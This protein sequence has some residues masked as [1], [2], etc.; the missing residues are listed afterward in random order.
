MSV[1]VAFMTLGCPKN[2][3]DTDAMRA[4]VLSSA[5]EL[6]EDIDDADVVVLNTCSFI[7]EATEESITVALQLAEEWLPHREGRRLL[8]AG[9]MPSRY[10]DDLASALV[11]VDSFIPVAEED[12][13]LARIEALTGIGSKPLV[14]G[15]RVLR[16]VSGPSA[17]VKISDGCDRTCA[18]CAIPSIRGPYRSRTEEAVLDEIE[19]LA[20]GGVRE[21]VLIGQ[22]TGIWGRDLPG[23]P[24]LAHLLRAVAARVPGVWIRVMYLQPDGIDDELLGTMAELDSVCPYFDIPLQHASTRVLRAMHRRGSYDDFIDLVDRIRTMVPG[25]VVRTTVIAGFPGETREEA[26]RL[27]QFIEE[28]RFDYVGV[29][30]YSQE[31]GTLASVMEDQV[32]M[33]TR[34]AR[35]QRLR[36]AA[37]RIGFERAAERVGQVH[38]VLVE[39]SEDE[40]GHTVMLGRWMGQAP[41][42][43]GAVHLP[44]GQ[45]GDML[46]VRFV[47]SFCYELEGEVTS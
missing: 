11:E 36:D 14:L 32:P 33:R 46:R 26:A 10:G 2:E 40:D 1:R 27:L 16:T 24:R 17:Y 9:C 21:V 47:D 7:Q 22:D 20:A 12:T 15:E 13:L 5:Y 25:A 23:K 6:S 43:D 4:A 28:A 42:I 37:D 38:D 39:S 34:K 30:P 41:E 31:E 45:V 18:Y 3:A 29:F 8:V 19:A 35:A 44:V